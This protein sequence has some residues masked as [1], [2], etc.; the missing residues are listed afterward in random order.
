VLM[1]AHND[2]RYLAE[3]VGS[4]LDQSFEDFEFLIVD[5]GSTDGSS[6]VLRSICDSRVQLITSPQNIGLTRSLNVGLDRARGRY[7][8]RM[9]ADDVAEPTRLEWQVDAM[10]RQPDLGLLGTGR[11]LID[12]AGASINIARPAHGRAAVLWKMLLGNAFA[13]P[14]VMIRREVLERHQLRYDERYITAQ[15]YELW[16]RLMKHTN[17]DNLPEPLVRYRLRKGISQ[18][19][20]AEQR[21]NHDRI[22]SQ[23]IRTIVPEFVTSPAEVMHLRGRYGGFSVRE[24]NMDPADPKWVERYA[25]LR[26]AFE[27]RHGVPRDAGAMA[28]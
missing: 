5:D 6:E 22:A 11:L 20:K 17:A 15:D 9:D 26:C 19:R 16:V 12:D 21:A 13:H 8:A 10:E 4:I 14:T 25:A 28:A 18:T 23:A 24:A 27:R 1:S 7:V 2:R 3:S